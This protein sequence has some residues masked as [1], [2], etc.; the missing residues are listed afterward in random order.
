M[1]PRSR[2]WRCSKTASK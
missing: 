1:F 2:R